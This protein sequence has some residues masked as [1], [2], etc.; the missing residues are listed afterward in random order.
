[1]S[2]EEKIE[3]RKSCLQTAL[4]LMLEQLRSNKLDKYETSASELVS[5]AKKIET[6]VVQGGEE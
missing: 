6:Y 2:D 4:T 1:M 5:S 3:V